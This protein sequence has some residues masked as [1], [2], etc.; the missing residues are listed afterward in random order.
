MINKQT[1]DNAE[2]TITNGQ[3]RE[4]SNARQSQTIQKHKVLTA[5]IDV[6][7]LMAFMVQTVKNVS[8]LLSRKF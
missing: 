3:S 4:T 2:G 6:L 7:V 1:L 5:V 8:I